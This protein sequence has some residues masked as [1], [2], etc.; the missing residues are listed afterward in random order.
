MASEEV[1]DS[2]D[3]YDRILLNMREYP[4]DIPMVDGK[5]SESFREYIKLLFTPEEA[6]IAQHLTVRPQKARKIAKM[7]GIDKEEAK[8]IL[9]EMTTKGIIQDT[10]GYSLF[11]TFAWL[12]NIPYKYSKS[13]ERMQ[14]TKG[15]ELYQKF[16]IEEKFYKRYESSDKGT[17]WNRVLPIGKTIAKK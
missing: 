10:A 7:L 14:G 5:V 1:A 13:L 17:A 15:G 4:N 6:K 8:K 3:P 2:M 12:M 9:D 16:F 11:M